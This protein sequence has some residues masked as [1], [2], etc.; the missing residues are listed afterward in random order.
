[1]KDTV[2]IIFG[3]SISYGLY[4]KES[5]GWVNRTRLN[6]NNTHYI[7]NLAIPGQSSKDILIKF[8]IELKNR[9]NDFDNFKLIFAFGIKDA[10]LLNK[11]NNHINIFKENVFKIIEISKKYTEDINFIGLIKPDFNIRREYN[12]EYVITIDNTL[13]M[14]DEVG[15]VI[16]VDKISNANVGY[17]DF[18]IK[19]LVDKKVKY[20]IYLTNIDNEDAIQDKFIKVYLTDQKE[21]NLLDFEKSSVVTYYDLKLADS[22]LSGKRI[23][24][25]TLDANQIRKFRL[26]MWVADTYALNPNL[27]KF[28][29]KLNV[30]VR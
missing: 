29:V 30:K 4:D 1:M 26:R 27:K 2:S 23:Y 24:Y 13:P 16:D 3:D 22:D 28:S 8:E 15:K 9:Y 21:N 25:D 19:S 12:L 11:D 5:L 14:T 17:L 10:L 20:E 6:L 7:F 18:E